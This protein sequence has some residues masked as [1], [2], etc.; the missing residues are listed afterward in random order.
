MPTVRNLHRTT[1]AAFGTYIGPR[2]TIHV[3]QEEFDA[4][5]DV[6]PA[7]AHRIIKEHLDV[8]P[9]A[10][11][12]PEVEPE[13]KREPEDP[14]AGVPANVKAIALAIP[15]VPEDGLTKAGIPTTAAL[16]AL[17]GHDV[18]AKERDEAVAAWEA[19]RG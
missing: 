14:Y 18:S 3:S 11:P 1:V 6:Y 5:V 13:P 7:H 16:E 8:T 17:L 4:W 9:D 19:A 2:A 12:A 10:D 15:N